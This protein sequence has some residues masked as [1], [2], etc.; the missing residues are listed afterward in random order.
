MLEHYRRSLPT[1][2]ICKVIGNKSLDLSLGYEL[3]ILSYSVEWL[4]LECIW[5]HQGVFHKGPTLNWS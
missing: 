5:N 1:F 2:M 4:G 3:P